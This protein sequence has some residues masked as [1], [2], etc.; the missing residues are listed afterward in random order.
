MLVF[1]RVFTKQ[2]L[3]KCNLT[4]FK[5]KNKREISVSIYMAGFLIHGPHLSDFKMIV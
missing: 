2:T 3:L 1:V 5:Q 4:R